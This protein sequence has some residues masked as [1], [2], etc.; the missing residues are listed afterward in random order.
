MVTVSGCKGPKPE[1]STAGLAAEATETEAAVSAVQ[2]E[3]ASQSEEGQS[4]GDVI[5]G[6]T[7]KSVSVS[8]MLQAKLIGFT[9]EKKRGRAALGKKQ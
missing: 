8:E 3:P 6:F 2:E 7:V 9:H 5:S 1:E 4:E